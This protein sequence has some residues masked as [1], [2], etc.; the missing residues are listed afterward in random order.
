[1]PCSHAGADI[2]DDRRGDLDVAVH[3]ARLDVDLDELLRAR[4]A[5]LLALAVTEQPV[6]AGTDH[7][8]DI[9]VGQHGRAC[10]GGGLRMGVG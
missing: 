2:A 8:Y 7:H 9:A 4:R 6:E 3:L 10:G 5:P 1:M